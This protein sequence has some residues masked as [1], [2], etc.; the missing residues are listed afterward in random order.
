MKRSITS[1]IAILVLVV[2]VSSFAAQDTTGTVAE[3]KADNAQVNADT[4]RNFEN[5]VNTINQ[6]ESDLDGLRKQLR[7]AKNDAERERLRN[8]IDLMDTNID[9]LRLAWEMWATGG[10][11]LQIFAPKKEEKFDWHRKQVCSPA[12][13]FWPGAAAVWRW[14]F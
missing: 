7:E 14:A 8:E 12:I 1:L 10:V 11:D 3:S 6:A 2:S 4:W 13:D 9:N 5:L